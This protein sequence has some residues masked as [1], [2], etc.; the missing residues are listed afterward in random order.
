MRGRMKDI[1]QS[2]RCHETLAQQKLNPT[3]TPRLGGRKEV[4]RVRR[5]RHARLRRLRDAR[6]LGSILRE[7]K[8]TLKA[9]SVAEPVISIQV[10]TIA[11]SQSLLA[12]DHRVP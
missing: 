3:E 9:T 2:C 12:V 1:S 11:G 5:E 6:P 7:V 4:R 8:E 10:L